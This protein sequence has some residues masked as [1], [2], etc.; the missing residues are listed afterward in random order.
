MVVPITAMTL[1][2]LEEF[3]RILLQAPKTV[4]N[5]K[6]LEAVEREIGKRRK[7]SQPRA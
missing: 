3:Q 6:Q 5:A 2:D 4:G 7:D 1:E